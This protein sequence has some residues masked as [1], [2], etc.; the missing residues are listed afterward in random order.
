MVKDLFR[1]KRM[2]HVMSG[3]PYE[4]TSGVK[5]NLFTRKFYKDIYCDYSFCQKM[6]Q[7]I[8]MHLVPPVMNDGPTVTLHMYKS[9]VEIEYYQFV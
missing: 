1:V 3:I 2:L 7:C 9:M 8:H 4:R 5:I 6:K